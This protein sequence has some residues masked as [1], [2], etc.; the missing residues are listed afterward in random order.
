MELDDHL[1]SCEQC[2]KALELLA[3]RGGEV[4]RFGTAGSG[5]VAHLAEEELALAG[6]DENALPEETL[7]HLQSCDACRSEVED[8]KQYAALAARE[9]LET[10]RVRRFSLWL[11]PAIGACAAAV[12]AVA[13]VQLFRHPSVAAPAVV[14]QLQDGGAALKLDAQGRLTGLPAGAANY[15]GL[16]AGVL[17][18]RSLPPPSTPLPAAPETGTLRGS[19]SALPAFQVI[20][21]ANERT[22]PEPRFCWSPLNG[23]R[24]Y[25]VIVADSTLRIVSRSPQTTGTCWTT[26]IA[27]QP[28]ETYTWNVV[29]AT[30]S[31][32]VQTPMPPMPEARFTVVGKEDM[33]VLED[34]RRAYPQSHLLFATLYAQLGMKTL[35]HDE[36]CALRAENPDS[37]VARELRDAASNQ[38]CPINTN[39]AQ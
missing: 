17:E 27:F 12:A 21:P 26:S 31:G 35:A 2:C 5:Q 11:W 3:L 6:R 15:A 38:A 19:S 13:G 8:A 14:A 25:R 39:P 18:K 7:A 1:A 4:P 33:S 32:E 10:A 23:A 22:L 24:G 9:T 28:G 20:A 30:P 16:L 36:V 34:A 37:T 29:A